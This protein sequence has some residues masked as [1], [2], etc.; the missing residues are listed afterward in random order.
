MSLKQTPNTTEP[1]QYVSECFE[2]LGALL[3]LFKVK[4]FGSEK[5]NTGV[6][7]SSA[8]LFVF[9]G[10]LRHW[11]L[12]TSE[13]TFDAIAIAE[14][15]VKNPKAKDML[16]SVSGGLNLFVNIFAMEKAVHTTALRF[17]F[18]TAPLF[19]LL[20]LRNRFTGPKHLIKDKPVDNNDSFASIPSILG[21]VIGVSAGTMFYAKGGIPAFPLPLKYVKDFLRVSAHLL[22]A[23]AIMPQLRMFSKDNGFQTHSPLVSAGI[24]LKGLG[25]VI[26][27]VMLLTNGKLLKLD[28]GSLAEA[29]QPLLLLSPQK[30]VQ[31]LCIPLSV[32][33]YVPFFLQGLARSWTV[34]TILAVIIGSIYA[35]VAYFNVDPTIILAHSTFP[36]TALLWVAMGEALLA[37][38]TIFFSGSSGILTCVMVFQALTYIQYQRAGGTA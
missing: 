20:Q 27:L 25:R 18:I 16:T 31:T 36:K 32:L 35:S 9:A 24:L 4:P 15:A 17:F 14:L 26:L 5:T 3:L 8:L 19:L 1:L 10:V 21:L 2:L 37:I 6:S 13:T 28:T 33:L 22:G 23:L 7:A 30:I 29:I 38:W 34:R 11:E 12:F